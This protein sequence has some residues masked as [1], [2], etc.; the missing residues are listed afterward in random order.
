MRS[1]KHA[2]LVAGA[3]TLVTVPAVALSF[4]SAP[5]RAPIASVALLAVEQPGSEMRTVQWNESLPSDSSAVT[6]RQEIINNIQNNLNTMSDAARQTSME[7]INALKQQI[8]SIRVETVGGSVVTGAGNVT[9]AAVTTTASNAAS[10][11][12]VAG[13]TSVAGTAVT[14]A[15]AGGAAAITSALAPILGAVAAATVAAAV[16]DGNTETNLS[17]G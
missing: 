12:A 10:T 14:T 11:T 6:S 15:V 4:Q 2:L 9:S 13:V 1:V 3:A 17:P 5:A 7:T 16:V 8:A